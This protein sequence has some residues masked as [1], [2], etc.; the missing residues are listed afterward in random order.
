MSRR[1]RQL[2]GQTGRQSGA[3]IFSSL[4]SGPGLITSPR[5]PHGQP[6]TPSRI[7]I[8]VTV[9]PSDLSWLFDGSVLV[10]PAIVFTVG[11]RTFM[12]TFGKSFLFSCCSD[13]DSDLLLPVR[14]FNLNSKREFSLKTEHF[15]LET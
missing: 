6:L 9:V 3:N 2:S 14:G 12:Q 13:S 1:R 8:Y 11:L 5:H 15:L 4:A 10:F 7:Y